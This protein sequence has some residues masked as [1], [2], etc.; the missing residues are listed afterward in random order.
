VPTNV[1][2]WK[3][4]IEVEIEDPNSLQMYADTI[5]SCAS[6]IKHGRSL[7]VAA[8]QPWHNTNEIYFRREMIERE[9]ITNSAA[10]LFNRTNRGAR[11]NSASAPLA[12]LILPLQTRRPLFTVRR[13]RDRRLPG[14]CEAGLAI[15]ADSAATGSTGKTAVCRKWDWSPCFG[16]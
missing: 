4:R 2:I 13:R 8:E 12:P 11:Y 10:P 3:L 1:F 6:G 14:W 9:P 15:L 16:R 5:R 7:A